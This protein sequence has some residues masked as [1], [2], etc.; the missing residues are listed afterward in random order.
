MIKYTYTFLLLLLSFSLV[1]AQR[2]RDP[3]QAKNATELELIFKENSEAQK[4]LVQ[5][6]AAALNIPLREVL[7][8]GVERE[9]V[10]VSKTG[11]PIYYQTTNNLDA[12]RTISTNKVWPLG[13]LGLNLSGI[14]MT[15]RLGVWDG[16]SVL[17]SHQEFQSRATQTDGASGL[18]DHAT[19]VAGTMSAGGVV[20]NAKGMS[21]QA[22]IK[23]YDWN[24]DAS[25]M[26]S[27]AS[28]GMLVS[29]HSYSQ[30]S[31][32]QYNDDL[33]RWEFWSDPNVSLTED[34]KYGFYDDISEQWDQIAFSYPNYLPFVAAGNDRNEPST[35]PSTYY[36]RN[37]NGSWVVG[38]STNKPGKVGPY[39]SIRVQ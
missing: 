13:S 28:I 1:Q 36:I 17:T 2:I 14:G 37:T 23:C 31:G 6:K 15:N 19:H 25:E 11:M 35:I 22:P 32:W 10:A 34:H 3:R 20:A 5:A 30:I 39:N 8:N 26:S 18:S 12:A 16:G 33:N 21:Y 29:N 27:A 24:S 9:F 7:K 4:K 38:S